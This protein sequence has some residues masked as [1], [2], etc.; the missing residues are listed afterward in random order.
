MKVE[1]IR[2]NM[3]LELK[4]ERME[5]YADDLL[6]YFWFHIPSLDKRFHRP[7]LNCSP[8]ASG[9]ELEANGRQLGRLRGLVCRNLEFFG[10][11]CFVAIHESPRCYVRRSLIPMIENC[12][13]SFW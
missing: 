9:I 2:E 13:E 10:M 1:M 6:S 3:V 7:L 12:Q 4:K 11:L 8:N 5:A